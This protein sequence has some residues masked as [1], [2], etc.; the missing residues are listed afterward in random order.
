MEDATSKRFK[1]LGL[2]VP[3]VPEADPGFKVDVGHWETR[4]GEE[5]YVIDK[6]TLFDV[7]VR[8]PS[9][10]RKFNVP[11]SEPAD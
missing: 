5:V 1:R 10:F 8:R 7:V 2:A 11:D 3:D 9:A 6:A 4:D